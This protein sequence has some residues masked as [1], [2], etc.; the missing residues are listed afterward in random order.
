MTSSASALSTPIL[1]GIE[2]EYGIAIRGAPAVDPVVASQLLLAGC[3]PAIPARAVPPDRVRDD[4]MLPNGAR[5][6]VDHAHPEYS[7]PEC[8]SFRDL[9]AADRAGERIVDRCRALVE[10]EGLLASG[11]RLALYK[12]NSDGAGNSYGCHENYLV[13]R[14][15]W[16]AVVASAAGMAA[17]VPFI[18]TRMLLCGAGKVG[19][20]NATTPVGF[21]LSQ[22]ADFIEELRGV[23]TTYR[24]PLLNL[25]DEAHARNYR[26]LHVIVGD[27]NLAERSTWL[28]VGTTALVLALIEAGRA[29][30]GFRLRDPVHAIREVSRDLTFRAQLELDGSGCA[31]ALEVQRAF[32]AAARALVGDRPQLGVHRPILDAWH[33][34]LTGIAEDWTRLADRIDWAVKRVL[35]ERVLAR[36]GAVWDEVVAWQPVIE[37]TAELSRPAVPALDDPESRLDADLGRTRAARVR[38]VASTAGIA[39]GEYWQRRDLHYALRRID[40]E[41]H[42]IRAA[43]SAPALFTRLE[44]AG[45]IN[46]LIEDHEIDARVNQP[47]ADTRAWIR[48]RLIEQFAS[49]LLAVDWS[50]VALR[51]P[52]RAQPLRVE[53][54]DPFA[55]SGPCGDAWL[56]AIARHVHGPA[57]DMD[58]MQIEGDHE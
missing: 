5:F 35:L 21:Q 4:L 43:S 11:Q 45:V 7:T 9:V 18:V 52:G 54:A 13:S 26:R 41:Y 44:Q 34:A 6:Y 22:R 28:K 47:P 49:Q 31:T 17:F 15:T 30:A 12:N 3:R 16:D 14:A 50:E 48:G 42:E 32:L 36:N 29:P 53:L 27:A 24:R 37:A 10:R 23:Q 25:R 57:R 38:E 46:R 2:T 33:D 51:V 1:A 8:R 40:L 56:A 39:W 58:A 19:A 55:G 20:E